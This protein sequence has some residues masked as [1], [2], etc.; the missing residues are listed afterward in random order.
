MWCMLCQHMGKS[1]P[2]EDELKKM[3]AS[4]RVYRSLRTALHDEPEKDEDP[5]HTAFRHVL[6]LD[7]TRNECAV[8]LF[9]QML[10]PTVRESVE[11]IS[12]P[13]FPEDDTDLRR[14]ELTARV[15]SAIERGSTAILVGC[16]RIFSAFYDVFNKHYRT[17]LRRAPTEGGGDGN[18]GGGPDEAA[19]ER[20][21]ARQARRHFY[22]YIGIGSFSSTVI[23]H[24]SARL[25]VHMSLDQFR[26]VQLPFL[27]RFEKYKLTISDVLEERTVNLQV[28]AC[29]HLVRRAVTW[30]DVCR[31]W[32]TRLLRTTLWQQ[33]RG[34]RTPRAS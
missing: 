27:N 22:A 21:V 7:A 12:M 19:A 15:K 28:C 3:L 26:R 6:L 31:T 29:L 25:I 8:S 24:P 33:S 2:Q 18:G 17:V 11:V 10:D 34:T 32:K 5:S 1:R 30:S 23:V 13:D 16:D 4:A 20:A 9:L 14:S